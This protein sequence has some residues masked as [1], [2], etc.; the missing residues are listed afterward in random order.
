MSGLYSHTE[1][2]NMCFLFARDCSN[3]GILQT[4]LPLHQA[5]LAF[6]DTSSIYISIYLNPHTYTY[7]KE[8]GGSCHVASSH[9]KSNLWIQLILHRFIKPTQQKTSPTVRFFFFKWGGVVYAWGGGV[10]TMVLGPSKKKEKFSFLFN[11][12]DLHRKKFGTSSIGI[13]LGLIQT[14]SVNIS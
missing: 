3:V 5:I 7:Q 4:P 6:I 9:K 2:K 11:L 8:R 14:Q 12:H 1:R 10:A 13:E